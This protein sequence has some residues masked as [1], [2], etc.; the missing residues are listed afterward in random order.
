MST[1]IL[2]WTF[3]FSL[4]TIEYSAVEVKLLY[5][6]PIIPGT[7]SYISLV[8]IFPEIILFSLKLCSGIIKI[9]LEKDLSSI[10]NQKQGKSFRAETSEVI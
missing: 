10:E 7:T 6:Y 4:P 2:R 8:E 3:F 5:A 1:F 9:A